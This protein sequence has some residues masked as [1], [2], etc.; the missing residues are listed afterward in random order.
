MPEL[1]ARSQATAAPST[2]PCPSVSIS[3]AA[4]LTDS[5]RTLGSAL[6]VPPAASPTMPLTPVVGPNDRLALAPLGDPAQSMWST[7]GRAGEGQ[8]GPPP[9]PL[10]REPQEMHPRQTAW[11]PRPSAQPLAGSPKHSE[12]PLPSSQCPVHLSG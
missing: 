6:L 1:E 10:P 8:P 12:T 4:T 9:W 7:W 5:S 3:Q 2:L 11:L